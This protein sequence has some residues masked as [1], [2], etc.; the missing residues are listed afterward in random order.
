MEFQNYLEGHIKFLLILSF[1]FLPAIT[2]AALTT[3]IKYADKCDKSKKCTTRTIIL[4]LFSALVPSII[5]TAVDDYLT[6]ILI[7]SSLRLGVAF[8]FG[9]VGDEVLEIVTSLRKMLTIL[10]T[11]GKHIDS[12]K[13]LSE[14]TGEVMHELNN[15]DDSDDSDDDDPKNPPPDSGQDIGLHLGDD[16]DFLE[17]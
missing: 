14:V 17:L 5:L 11:L 7:E 8:I 13:K 4:M 2:G 6:E 10:K 1:Y 3:F 9:C 12:V 16:D 15:K